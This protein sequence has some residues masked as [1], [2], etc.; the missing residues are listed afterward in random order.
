MVQKIK[1]PNSP[2]AFLKLKKA[3]PISKQRTIYFER[4]N[5]HVPKIKDWLEK[6]HCIVSQSTV[7]SFEK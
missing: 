5:I 7:A 6:M 4:K 2:G 3:K 1:D